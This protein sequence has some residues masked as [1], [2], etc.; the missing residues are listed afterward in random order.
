MLQQVD[1]GRGAGS[2]RLLTPPPPRHPSAPIVPA[3]YSSIDCWWSERGIHQAIYSFFSLLCLTC[4]VCAISVT[5]AS[6]I[7]H[8]EGGSREAR[9]RLRLLPYLNMYLYSYITYLLHIYTYTYVYLYSYNTKQS[10]YSFICFFSREHWCTTFS[11]YWSTYSSSLIVVCR[12]CTLIL[13]V[14]FPY[15]LLRSLGSV[16]LSFLPLTP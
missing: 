9:F 13:Y 14:L 12:S 8:Q 1:A 15:C 11:H 6:S 3:A 5:C 7:S 16:A 4:Y 10:V 2:R